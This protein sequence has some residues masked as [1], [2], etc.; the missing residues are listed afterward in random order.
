MYDTE[1]ALLVAS[2]NDDL[3]LHKTKK[4]AFFLTLGLYEVGGAWVDP[5]SSEEAKEWYER[6]VPYMA[7]Q[8]AFGIVPEE[9]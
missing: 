7:Y 4:G 5:L 6:L 2:N 9:A 8:E 1:N 3:F